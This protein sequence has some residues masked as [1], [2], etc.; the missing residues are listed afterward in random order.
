MGDRTI[1]RAARLEKIQQLLYHAPEGLS[2][3]ALAAR[4]A[5]HRTTM[6]R[7]IETLSTEMEAPVWEHAGRFGIDRTRYLTPVRLNLHEALALYIAARLLAHHSDEQNPHVVSALEKLATATP[8]PMQEHIARAAALVRQ[9]TVG[10][11]Y[12][13]ILEI[14]ARAWAERRRV[15]I[16]YR[17]AASE[18]RAF[19][20]ENAPVQRKDARDREFEPYFIEPSAIGYACY[21]IGFDHLH[22]CLRTFKIERIE[23]A[24]LLAE[25]YE[26]PAD[27]DPYP[28]LSKSWG[29][30]GGDE[31]QEVKLR[32]TPAVAYRV[33]E[34]VWHPS[35][36]IED[37]PDGGCL[38]TVHIA[39]PLEMKWWIRSWGPEV[40]VLAPE[41]LREEMRGEVERMRDM[42]QES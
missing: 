11:R 38:F 40:E 6:Y 1:N 30:M 20:G 32:F 17:S 13:S 31:D 24:Q 35:Q 39:H 41:G 37:L 42:Y 2:V 12:V 23:R 21:C 26:I 28:Y 4:C 8:L 25:T 27:F 36:A 7:D 14:L 22:G 19:Q 33:K 16:W 29:I 3:A 15:H 5:V 34:S 10:G 9:R 18:V